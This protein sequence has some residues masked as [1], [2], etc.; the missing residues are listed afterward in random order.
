[1]KS[2]LIVLL[3]V[4]AAA[5]SLQAQN[6]SENFNTAGAL[7]SFNVY[8]NATPG[9]G[10]PYSEVTSGGVGGS[11]AIAVAVGGTAVTADSTLIYKNSVF[12]F[13]QAGLG[14]TISTFLNVSTQT[15]G[16]NRLMQLGFVNENTS[17][18]NGNAGLAFASLRLGSTGTSGN[19]YTPQFQT[20]T[21]A[22]STVNTTLAPNLTLTVG[23]WYKLSGT[24]V[25]TGSGNI[26]ASGFLQDFGTDGQTAGSVVFSFPS[27]NLT[28]LDIA[29][30]STVYA[31]LRGFKADGLNLADN[32]SAATVVPEPGSAALL[33]AALG[34]VLARNRKR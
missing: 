17:G 14:L 9:L 21:A 31:A 30:D 23:N 19:I 10:S 25:N 24:F 26:Q 4:F 22:G 32:F 29:S 2:K 33:L 1:M 16:G 28:S 34:A 5:G 7:G 20:K 13:S 15:A 3:C 12:D 18:M 8:Q 6:F 11:G 27:T